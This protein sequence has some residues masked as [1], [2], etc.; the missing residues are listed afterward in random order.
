MNVAEMAYVMVYV[1]T[2]IDVVL[3]VL[4]V[5]QLAKTMKEW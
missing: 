2:A 1:G 4:V 3:V 5:K